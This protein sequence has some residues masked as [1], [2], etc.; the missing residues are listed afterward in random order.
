MATPAAGD[1]EYRT[2][3]LAVECRSGSDERRIGG[4]AAVVGRRSRLLP[5][6]FIEQ[7][8]GQFF[9]ESRSQ[10]FADVV[11]RAEHDSRMLLGT[12]HSGTLQLA[13]DRRGLD[14]ECSLTPA[15]Q[16]VYESVSRGDYGGSSITFLCTG[17][18]WGYQGG[19]PLRTL[20]SGHLRDV[21]PVT[22]PAYRDTSVALR[23]LA[24]FVDAPLEDVEM[25]SRC[26]ELRRFFTRTDQ[27]R[28]PPRGEEMSNS[29][30]TMD[31][32]GASLILA[33]RRFPPT[34]K[35]EVRQQQRM[36]D[37]VRRTMVQA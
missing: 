15:R 37:E 35:A 32:R 26:G 16:D 13:L 18:D 28:Y 2:T 29:R 34:T 33:A 21:G 24:G 27:P 1:F 10:G 36:V 31:W 4:M 12:I 23:S 5:G 30:P 14:Y 6:G 17:D 25:Y 9:N 7:I 22:I 3:P 20:R 8:D 11:C 19:T